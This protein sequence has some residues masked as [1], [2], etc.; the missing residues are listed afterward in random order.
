MNMAMDPRNGLQK[1][2]LVHEY[3]A[4]HA[5]K[6]PGFPACGFQDAVIN[7]ARL[8]AGANR[9]AHFLHE[10]KIHPGDTVAVMLER[11][12]LLMEVMIGVFRAG[13]I[14]VP[15]NP[16]YPDEKIRHIIDDCNA[17]LI[18]TDSLQRIP[19]DM[20]F[21]A[22]LINPALD[23]LNRLPDTVPPAVAVDENSVAYVIYTS[24]TT[25]QPKGVMISHGNLNN[26]TEWY[27]TL[28]H[29]SH[30]DRASQFASQGF[31]SFFCE[32]I[33]FFSMGASVH[34][35]D[36]MTRLTP[37]LFFAWLERAKI[38]VCDLPTSWANVL[39]G[40]IWPDIRSLRL[41]KIGGESLKRYP[42][43]TFGFELWNIYGPAEATIETTYFR[44]A[45]AGQS[46]AENQK[47]YP[48]PP[49]GKPLHHV[50]CHIVDSN[51]NPVP[52][53]T[54]GELLIGGKNVSPG[55]LNR[56]EPD[57]EKFLPDTFSGNPE[58]RVYR[59]GDRVRRLADGNL[60]YLGRLDH[61]IKI[62]GCQIE[63]LEIETHLAS[64]PDVSEVVVLARETPDGKKSL[65]AWL[66]PNM[67][68]IRIPWHEKCLVALD[69]S[70]YIEA[71]SEDISREGIA[72]SGL[73]EKISTKKPV[74]INV[75]LPGAADS[76]W[77]EGILIWQHDT[78]AGIHFSLSDEEKKYLQ[79]SVEFYLS[80]HNIMKTLENTSAKRSLKMALKKKLPENMIPDVFCTLPRFPLT[81]NCKVDTKSLPIPQTASQIS[82]RIDSQQIIDD[83]R[84]AEDIIPGKVS[85]QS[86]TAPE[87]ILLTGAD[88][89]LGIYLLNALLEQTDATIHCMIRKGG[90]SSIA[91]RFEEQVRI[92]GLEKNVNLAN[93]RIVLVSGDIALHHFDLPLEHYQHLCNVDAI[94]HCG[95]QVN[96]QASYNRLRDNNVTGTREIIQFAVTGKT[97][98]VYYISALSAATHKNAAGE[99]DE[100]F[101]EPLQPQ[102]SGGYA[103]TKWVSERL[104]TEVK[105]RGLPVHIYRLGHILGDSFHGVMNTN[106]PLLLLIRGCIQLGYAPDWEE[107]IAV[108]PVDFVSHAIV[109]LSGAAPPKSGVYH[110]DQPHGMYWTEFM[111]WFQ[112]RG[113][114]IQICSHHEW[115]NLL[116]GIDRDNA[117]HPFLSWYL[118]MNL[119][120]VTPQ[121]SM[122]NAMA[123]LQKAGYEYPAMDDRLLNTWLD[124]LVESGFLPTVQTVEKVP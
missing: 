20:L 101:P 119:P 9:I 2:R 78:R 59:T 122:I 43:Q 8:N 117:L 57:P 41:V 69:E 28:Y 116:A 33:P 75:L 114:Q 22:I 89:F 50:Q 1:P 70:R 32:T 3:V 87:N 42:Q 29:L 6:N 94:W 92:F 35:V 14:F 55:Y 7:Y 64:H 16:K 76:I 45:K 10:K 13:A 82:P 99:Y 111:K 80:S 113:Y 19:K 124:Y 15:L 115:L 66:V 109:C 83:C 38:S 88:G 123:G 53:G 61:D 91:K 5:E 96:T 31:D 60:E 37:A 52:D 105:Q 100:V 25:G 18:L 27:K 17:H 30:E 104:L 67:E 85:Q 36:D 49:I 107:L 56:T 34:I 68:K 112:R 23:P 84:L 40:Y 39:F 110:I 24:G 73:S 4:I 47:K 98:P 102:L 95:A 103:L 86:L 65:L 121:T 58:G 21:R 97:K 118:S 81:F 74:R 108:L 79:Q 44:M 63:L 12:P 54:A 26:L 51:L 11:T 90:F 77:L 93:Q 106:D 46:S 72:I 120:P 48:V 71:V 62:R